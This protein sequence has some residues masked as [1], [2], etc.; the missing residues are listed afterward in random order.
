MPYYLSQFI[1]LTH[2]FSPTM[3][4]HV[5]V[6]WD[7]STDWSVIDLR[8]DSG[9]SLSGG[10]LNACLVYYP[11]EITDPNLTLVALSPQDSI[12]ANLRTSLISA[13]K[14]SS[15]AA[16]NFSGFVQEILTQPPTNGWKKLFPDS[17]GRLKAFLG[18]Q[19][20]FN[21][22]GVAPAFV[23]VDYTDNFDRADNASLGA[24]W[25]EGAGGQGSSLAISSNQCVLTAGAGTYST[26][27]YN[28][29]V[30]TDNQYAFITVV[31]MT[32][33]NLRSSEVWVRKDNT[34]ATNTN[35]K[36]E[37]RSDINHAIYKTIA[38]TETQL[39]ASS[40]TW[41]AGEVMRLEVNGTSLTLYKNGVAVNGAPVTDSVLSGST[42][43]SVAM[44]AYIFSATEV[45]TLD[46]WGGGDLVGH[47][48][49]GPM[50][51]FYSS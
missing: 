33:S 50:P 47:L 5:P 6:G 51:L 25:T 35:Y 28:S 37:A 27:Q 8:P 20:L 13:L 36:G 9:I 24:N 4:R 40:T 23:D 21:I 38:G 18:G 31:S 45:V 10:G 29:Q 30:S 11:F 49:R 17:G 2:P 15:L 39:L 42:Y 48:A 3:K 26:A 34:A 22:Q 7:K 44:A 32:G 19:C 43:R 14:L 46:N 41:A 12:G 1:E 16:G